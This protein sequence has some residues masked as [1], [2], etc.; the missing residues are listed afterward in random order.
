MNIVFILCFGIVVS[1]FFPS[2]SFALC[3]KEIAS[4]AIAMLLL[5]LLIAIDVSR[6][7]VCTLFLPLFL[8][9][10]VVLF[11]RRVK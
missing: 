10:P 8:C 1:I 5:L 7:M 11:T 2:F 3:M 9:I 6:A 4:F